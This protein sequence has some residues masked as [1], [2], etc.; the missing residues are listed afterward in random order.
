MTGVGASG[1][2]IAAL[3]SGAAGRT[4]VRNLLAALAGMAFMLVFHIMQ[5]FPTLDAFGGDNDSLLRLVEVRDLLAGQAWYDLTQYRMGPEGGFVMHWSRLVDA[6]IA[7]LVLVGTLLTGSQSSGEAFALVAWP[8]LLF[9]AALWLILTL[10][11]RLGG[12][13]ALL[14]ALVVG[15]AA[16]HFLA[17]F[18]PGAI[19]HH[20]IQ[21]VLTLAAAAAL[22]RG[23]FAAGGAA[24]VA[25]ALMLGVGMEA[26]PYVAVAGAVAA[27]LIL[28]GRESGRAT[29]IGFG[30]AFALASAA[31]LVATVGPG[32]WTV[33]ACDAFSGVH[34]MLAAVAGSGLA[35]LGHW[36]GRAPLHIRVGAMAA[37]AAALVGL[38]VLLMPQCLADPYAALDPRLKTYWLEQVTEAQSLPDIMKGAPLMAAGYYATPLIGLIIVALGLRQGARRET[39]VAGAFLAAA[40][41]VSVWQVRGAI[42]SIPLAVAPLAAWIGVWRERAA[43]GGRHA[44]LGMAA[45]WLVSVNA[46]WTGAANALAPERPTDRTAAPA[47]VCQSGSDYAELAA[48]P[49][50][51]VMAISNLGAPILR[52]TPHRTLAGPYHR[53]IAGN[54]AALDALMGAPDAARESMRRWGATL[55]AV[56]PGNDETTAIV[57]W[58]PT[59]LLARVVAGDVPD[60]LRPLDTGAGALRVYSIH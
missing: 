10:A 41:A 51:S 45:A 23:G 55:L 19:D 40:I 8:A 47:G 46:V 3:P 20:N 39:L 57:E 12:E 44:S 26:S 5:G 54:L 11:R 17:I 38:I 2:G 6:P 16:L 34:F 24:G 25:S 52:F 59:G 18:A 49:A 35:A 29:A 31:T 21:L 32:A 14:P 36:L 60:W 22:M 42:F 7:F 28:W 53:N 37:L 58:A 48:R 43:V 30:L 1:T 4:G 50:A 27:G 13:P 56:C 33:V 9:A 15:G